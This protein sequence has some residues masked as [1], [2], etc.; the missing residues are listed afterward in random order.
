MKKVRRQDCEVL[1]FHIPLH[2]VLKYVVDR[3]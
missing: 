3:Q 1:L 2:L